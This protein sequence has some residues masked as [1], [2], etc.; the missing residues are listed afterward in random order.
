MKINVLVIIGAMLIANVFGQDPTI[1]V[2]GD[3]VPKVEDTTLYSSEDISFAAIFPDSAERKF[4][5]GKPIE[6]VLGFANNGNNYM[7]ISH[8]SASLRYPTDWRVHIQNFTKQQFEVIVPPSE[9][10]SLLY[11]F[12]PDP[13]LE[14]R[15]FGVS[16]V[17]S[18]LILRAETSPLFSS[19]TQSCWLSQTKELTSKQSSH[20]LVLLVFLV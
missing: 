10:V 13:M 16:L 8:I 17:F 14:P 4:Q 3:A 2:S 9:Q 12:Y 15:D 7:N 1:N 6:L 18:T 5:T 19:T 20:T 11:T